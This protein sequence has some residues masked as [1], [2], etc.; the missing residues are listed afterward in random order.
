MIVIQRGRREGERDRQRQR[1]REREGGQ[2]GR[3]GIE[4]R[5]DAEEDIFF[6]GG[7][8]RREG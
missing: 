8:R 4:R 5:K 1:E 3:K 6:A 7:Q 2:S